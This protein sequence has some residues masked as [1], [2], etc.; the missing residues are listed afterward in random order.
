MKAG[1]YVIRCNDGQH[2]EVHTANDSRTARR[3][4]K[5]FFGQ[6]NF[7]SATRVVDGDTKIYSLKGTPR[8]AT[9]QDCSPGQPVEQ[10]TEQPTEQ[11]AEQP[12]EQPAEQPAEQP[13]CRNG[14]PRTP[15]QRCR[16]CHKI[17]Q[18][19]YLKAK[20]VEELVS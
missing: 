9:I 5:K 18:Q 14:H 11:P 1:T 16:E 13:Q 20:K 4:V 19:R 15:G 3:M 2:E 7:H 17:S 10:P 6:K 12:T 8:Q